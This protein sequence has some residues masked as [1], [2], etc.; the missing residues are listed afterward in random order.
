MVRVTSVELVTAQVGRE[1][2]SNA[3]T[4]P[5]FI[6]RRRLVVVW[7][8]AS[9]NPVGDARRQDNTASIKDTSVELE[10]MVIVD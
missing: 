8:A 2:D 3:V 10:M 7:L 4:T 6:E 9:A 1:D 5:L